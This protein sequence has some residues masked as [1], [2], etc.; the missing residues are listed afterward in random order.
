MGRRPTSFA[1]GNVIPIQYRHMTTL[2]RSWIRRTNFTRLVVHGMKKKAL[3]GSPGFLSCP[4][5][6]LTAQLKTQAVGFPQTGCPVNKRAE[7]LAQGK[8]QGSE[9]VQ[10]LK[11][12]P[13]SY[14]PDSEPTCF[15]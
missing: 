1:S 9:E 5:W 7:G 15:S 11:Q 8:S 13:V 10:G 3:S 2:K 6:R 12:L 14:L 4:R